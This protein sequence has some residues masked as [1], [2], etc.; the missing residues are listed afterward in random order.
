LYCVLGVVVW[1]G[2]VSFVRGAYNHEYEEDTVEGGR[3]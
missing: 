2:Y 1:V 3:E